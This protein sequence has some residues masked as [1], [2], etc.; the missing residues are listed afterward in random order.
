VQGRCGDGQ[1]STRSLTPAVS[2]G[3]VD[4]VDL[5]ELSLAV[6]KQGA[7]GCAAVHATAFVFADTAGAELHDGL[8]TLFK[9]PVAGP[10]V[11]G[12]ERMQGVIVKTA[13]QDL[14]PFKVAA[15]VAVAPDRSSAVQIGGL[16]SAFADNPVAHLNES[17]TDEILKGN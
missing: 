4:R 7:L 15:H 14:L 3:G 12:P 11:A 1:K 6:G 16:D 5:V 17:D 9:T 13:R 10:T 2:S 8:A